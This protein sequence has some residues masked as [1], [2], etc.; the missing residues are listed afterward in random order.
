MTLHFTKEEQA[1]YE[2]D[3][4][5]FHFE[6]SMGFLNAHKG[7]RR[8]SFHLIL[9][10]TGGGK[11]TLIR[12]IIRDFLFKKENQ[13]LNL[14]LWLSEETIT[15]YKRQLS[16]SIP[17]HDV[18]LNTQAMS[19]LDAEY[20]QMAFFEWLEFYKPDVFIFDNITTSRFYMD[21][22]VD[23]QGAFA[24][25]LKAVVKKIDCAAILIAHT[26]AEVNDNIERFININDIRGSKSISNLTEFAYVL[27]RYEVGT[28]FYPTIRVVKHRS[29]DLVHGLYMLNY[30]KNLRAFTGD[31]PIQFEKLKEVFNA[32]N[33][34]K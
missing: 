15:D 2:A 6:S 13:N 34:L 21:R 16:A 18:L 7:L 24:R 26:S 1:N 9:G 29:Q 31:S 30:D 3:A 10:T 22:R 33:K 5:Q 8:G 28:S 14:S 20:S 4:N 27:Q 11:S 19:E 25:K 17:S 23:E 32:R 12:T